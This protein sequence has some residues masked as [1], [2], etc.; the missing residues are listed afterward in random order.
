M[1]SPPWPW[2]QG[3]IQGPGP[4]GWKPF[5]LLEQRK[6]PGLHRPFQPTHCIRCCISTTHTRGSQCAKYLRTNTGD[7]HCGL[8]AT[9]PDPCPDA[10]HLLIPWALVREQ[11]LMRRWAFSDSPLSLSHFQQKGWSCVSELG[12]RT[13]LPCTLCPFLSPAGAPRPSQRQLPTY[14]GMPGMQSPRRPSWQCL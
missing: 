8:K 11:I 1:R 10:P 9:G 2:P 7:Q 12:G 4:L 6:W 13:R 5:S 14:R 3:A